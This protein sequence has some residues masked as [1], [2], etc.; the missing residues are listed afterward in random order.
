MAQVKTHARSFAGGEITP[1]LYGRIDLV[2]FQTGLKTALNFWTL[3]HGPSQNRPG[4]AF[5]NEVKD[6]TRAT[7][8]IPFSFNTT[9][10]YIIELGHQYI[11]WHTNGATLCETAQ[12]AT[13]ITVASPAVWT[14][15]AHG[16]SVGQW[17][18][19]AGVTGTFSTVVTG[20]F[21]KVATTPTANTFTL[22]DQAGNAI[23]S[24][25]K[26]IT[27][28][29]SAA[30]VYEIA[31][32]YDETDLFE[33]KFT[34][35]E[36]VLT[37]T[38]P[39]YAARELSR[40]GATSWALNTIT[41]QP[42]ISAPGAPTLTT[43]GPGGGT[44]VNN[45]YVCTAIA[46]E[47]LEESLASSS[48]TQSYDLT[49][50]GNYIDV[51]PP[52]VSGAVR[53]NIYK[54]KNGLY[55]FIGQTDGSA[56]RDNNVTPDAS[57]TPPVANTPISSANEYP[58]A[59]G[60]HESRRAFAGS[61]NKPLNYWLVRSATESNL[62]YSIPS[63]DSDPIIGRI[64]GSDLDAVRHVLSIDVLALL[65]ASSIVKIAPQNSDILTPTS[66]FPKQ[67]PADEGSSHVRPLL[68]SGSALYVG[69]ATQHVQEMKYQW[70]S[71]GHIVNDAS[72]MAP[73]MFDGYTLVDA[74]YSK[75]LK[76]AFYPR[77]DGVLL[78]F[79]YLP[80]QEVSGWHAHKTYTSNATVQSYFESVAA[81]KEGTEFP[82]YAVVKRTINSRTVRYIERL[83][84]RRIS[85]IANSFFVDSGITYS[86]ASAATIS[87]LW[88]LEGETVSV[89]TNGAVHAQCVVT[90]G[91]ISLDAAT[92]LAHIGLPITADH[93]GLPLALEIPGFG[94]GQY[95]QPAEVFLR[96]RESAGIKAGPNFSALREL[97]ARSN[98]NYDTPPSLKNGIVKITLD[99][100]WDKDAAVCVRQTDPLPLTILSMTVP[101]DLGG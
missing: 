81:I 89:L 50:A 72:I 11:R 49:V 34:Q 17:V 73:H 35:K 27:A 53:Y 87:G 29:G 63:Q 2:K 57:I 36:D 33:L 25:G 46:S 64:R 20:R 84:S 79:T 71:N 10:T 51:D 6:S 100:A 37:I 31:S 96:V 21:L 101:V 4:F 52:A 12:N 47:T 54:L 19:I 85:A 76:M 92:T 43:G 69:D 97:P 61:T 62:S 99:N 45:V 95:K 24:T 26:T 56:F 14:I 30:R 98:E 68:A 91:Q 74:C 7:R 77:S 28:F 94:Q 41:F 18:F 59:V 13:D 58:S 93:G 3:P 78:G 32:P 1:E 44:P 38:H 39:D 8:V 88:H 5:V 16:L 75:G 65:T 42:G 83:H 9:Q 66:A 70:Q 86:G 55:G 80:A 60:Y 15:A 48:A 67:I 82:V 90:N 23:N 22:S 40:S